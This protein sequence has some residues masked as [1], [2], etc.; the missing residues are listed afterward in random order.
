MELSELSKERTNTSLNEDYLLPWAHPQDFGLLLAAAGE[1][2][3]DSWLVKPRMGPNPQ[4]EQSAGLP[5]ALLDISE[6]RQVSTWQFLLRLC[7]APMVDLAR[8]QI[9][10][11]ETAGLTPELFLEVLGLKRHYKTRSDWEELGQLEESARELG[12][13]YD[14]PIT[15]LRLWNRLEA[16]QQEGWREIWT[17]R[18]LKKNI[19]REIIQDYY[20]LSAEDRKISLEKAREFS[21]GWKARSGTFPGEDLR[22]IVRD[23]RYPMAEARRREVRDFKKKLNYG[24]GIHLEIP[25]HLESNRLQVTLEFQSSA[26]L[27]KHLADLAADSNMEMLDKILN[28]L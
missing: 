3:Q 10:H 14:F 24:K 9:S 23:Y 21:S 1:R 11:A 12:R 8:Y 6:F 7:P 2:R 13:T 22:Q 17:H 18:N 26:E 16:A 28:L 15:I 20:D 19:I 27:K 25:R 5:V 4:E